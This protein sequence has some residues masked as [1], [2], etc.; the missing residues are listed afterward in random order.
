MNL[1]LQ[2]PSIVYAYVKDIR[3]AST[4]CSC[5]IGSSDAKDDMHDLN[6]P[7]AAEIQMG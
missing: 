3:L 2:K 1:F 7:L 4:R 5:L 6:L